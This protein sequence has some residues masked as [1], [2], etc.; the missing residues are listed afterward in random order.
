MG[1]DRLLSDV[2]SW[3]ALAERLDRLRHDT[4][5]ETEVWTLAHAFTDLDREEDTWSLR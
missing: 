4:E 2:E 5:E 1:S 3:K